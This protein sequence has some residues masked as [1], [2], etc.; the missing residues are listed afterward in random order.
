MQEPE[1]KNYKEKQAYYR[2]KYENRG[3]IVHI[4]KIIGRDGKVL[5]TGKSYTSDKGGI[6]QL[7]RR[8]RQERKSK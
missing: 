1:F 3:S 6:R 5:Q 8:A 7:K 4:S 2:D